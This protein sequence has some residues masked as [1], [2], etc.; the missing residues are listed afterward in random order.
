MGFSV[1]GAAAII[2]ASMLVAFG[3]WFTATANSF[4]QVSESRELR[5]DGVLESSNTA[6]E[7]VSATYNE[8]G[9]G[10]LVVDVN[11]TGAAGLSLNATDLLIDG[12]FVEGW[13]PDATVDGN[14]GTDLWLAGEQLTVT[15]DPAPAPDRVK[16]VTP[17]GVAD[18]GAVE[19]FN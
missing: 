17:S 1:S 3:M 11:N 10:R 14:G 2:F 13:Q 4:D 16:I 6:V 9:N 12:A 5:T 8:S 19:V 15:R 18:T 7:I